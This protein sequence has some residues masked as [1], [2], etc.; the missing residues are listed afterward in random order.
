MHGH[1]NV[2]ISFKYWKTQ[3][4]GPTWKMKKKKV[5]LKFIRNYVYLLQ[6]QSLV[7]MLTTLL[8]VT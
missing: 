1:L 3:R 6:P 5:V 7:A 2:K 8:D 4:E